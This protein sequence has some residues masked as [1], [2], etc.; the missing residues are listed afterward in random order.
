MVQ[1]GAYNPWIHAHCS[2]EQ[3]LTMAGDAGAEFILPVHHQTFKLSSEPYKEPIERLVLASGSSPDRIPI[4]NIGDELH[5][6]N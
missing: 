6:V 5:F 3:A 1:F 2:P 4:H